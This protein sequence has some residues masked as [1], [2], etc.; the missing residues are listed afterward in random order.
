MDL[1]LKV[2]SREINRLMWNTEKTISTAESC[3]AGRLSTLLSEFPGSSDYF[4]GG[5]VCYTEELK[6]RYLQVNPKIIETKSA[7]CEDVAKQMVIGAVELFNTDYAVAM[8]GFAGP[9]GGTEDSPVGSIWIA[10]GSKDEI[11]TYK[12][13]GNAGREQNVVNAT[14][15]ALTLLRDFLREDLGKD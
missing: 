11:V 6:K 5:I 1:Q 10:V 14:A 3:S 9:G 7:V 13:S 15:K 8:T 2:L 12:Q 4:V